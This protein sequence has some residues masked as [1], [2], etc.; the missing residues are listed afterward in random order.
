MGLHLKLKKD[1]K[2]Y[3]FVELYPELMVAVVEDEN[4][5][6]LEVAEDEVDFS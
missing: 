5:N 2:H 3:K 1:G 6:Q 4:G